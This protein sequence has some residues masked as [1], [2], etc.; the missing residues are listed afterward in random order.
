MP[1]LFADDTC[2]LV[3]APKPLTLR[4]KMNYELLNVL[5]WTKANKITVNLQKS[6]VLIIPS[7]ITNS[8]QISR[9]FLLMT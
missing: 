7:K 5:E 1:K 3:H 9:C 4:E 8:I 6:S 2:L